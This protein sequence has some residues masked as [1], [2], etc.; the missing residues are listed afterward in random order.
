MNPARLASTFLLLVLSSIAA[1]AATITWKNPAGGLWNQST[2]WQPAQVPG[3]LDSVVIDLAGAFS[4][5]VNSAATVSNLSLGGPG[6]NPTLSLTAG[7][8]TVSQSGTIHDGAVL[9]FIGNGLA[10]NWTIEPGGRLDVSGPSQKNLFHSRILNQG[11]VRWLTGVVAYDFS[12]ATSVFT[13]AA[14]FEI[15]SSDSWTFGYGGPMPRFRNEGTVRKVASTGNSSFGNL[16]FENFGNLLVDQGNLTLN[17]VTGTLTGSANIASGSRLIFAQCSITN[18]APVNFS[19]PG[20]STFESGTLW[21]GGAVQ[22]AGLQL[23]GGNLQLLPT[24]QGGSIT[25]LVLQ[26]I[27]LNGTHQITGQLVL[28]NSPLAGSYII[29]AGGRLDFTGSSTKV[30]YE[31]QILNLGTI[32]WLEGIIAYDSTASGSVLTNRGLFEIQADS[33]FTFGYSGSQPRIQNEATIRKFNGTGTTTFN[34]LAFDNL[35]SIVVDKGRLNFQGV[36]G[37]LEGTGDVALGASLTFTQSSL[38]NTGPATFT[39]SGPAT[40]D[41]GTLSLGGGAPPAGLRLAGG[42]LKLLPSFQGGTIT[43]LTLQGTQLTGTNVVT[44]LLVISNAPLSGRYLIQPSGRVELVGNAQKLFYD[45]HILNLGTLR[46]AEGTVNYD[47]TA[48]GSTFTNLGLWELAPSGTWTYGYSGATPRIRNEGTIRKTSGAGTTSLNNLRFENAGQVRVDQGRVN[49]QSIEGVISGTFE[50]AQVA[51]FAFVSASLTNSTPVS[52]TGP[53]KSIFES[54]SLWLGGTV[55]PAGLQLIGG[56]LYLLPTF[57]GGVITNLTLEGIRLNGTN[58]IAGSL[59]VSNAPIVGRYLI[60]P[61]GRLDLVGN[62]SK[63]LYDTHVLNLGTLRWLA[64]PVSYDGTGANSTLTNLG[65]WEIH[66]DSSWSYPYS[67]ARPSIRNEGTLRKVNGPGQSTFNNLAFNNAGQIVIDQGRLNLQGIDGNLTGSANIAQGAILAFSNCDLTNS[68]PISIT[69]LGKAVF[70]SGSLWLGGAAQPQGLQLT[71]GTLRLLPTFQG[72]TISNLVLQGIT[73]VGTN[74]VQGVLSTT[75]SAVHGHLVIEPGGRYDISGSGLS[76]NE[77]WHVLNLGTVRWLSGTI[78]YGPPA[79]GSRFTN[80]NLVEIHSDSSWFYG[81]SGQVPT[82]RNE[83]TVRKLNGTGTTHFQ[84]LNFENPGIIEVANGIL[85]LPASYIHSTGILRPTGG[86]VGVQAGFDVIGGTVE[87]TGTILGARFLGGLLSPGGESTG[88]LRFPNGL[89]LAPAVTV[90]IHATGP[91]PATQHDRIRVTGPVDLGG[92]NLQ[93][94]TATGIGFGQSALFLENDGLDAITGTFAGRDEGS[95]FDVSTRLYRIRYKT[96]TG[97]DVS[98]IRDDGGIVLTPRPILT[99]GLYRV[100]GLGTNFVHY[101]IE[102]ST[103]LTDWIEL[104]TVPANGGGEFQFDD[105]DTA[106]FP[107]RLYRAIG[108]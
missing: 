50:T 15:H 68:A 51:T 57:Q 90:R 38:T 93:V 70:E 17:G 64:G 80:A 8:L 71:G 7:V 75:N 92:A 37:S 30:L 81:Y 106:Q 89:S 86:S 47:F 95:L 48:S 13:N 78:T 20:R 16:Q 23:V 18:S 62:G 79:L 31:S 9:E 65:V 107:H 99:N 21:L 25:N 46:W 41:S 44:G 61:T 55:Q 43:N 54:G 2:N 19:G 14:L 74:R 72:G 85:N 76:P 102:A 11:T 108:P 84:N 77:E 82:F 1:S 33:S 91:T 101:R 36:V 32:R 67:G 45:S 104:G 69:G 59:V 100:L 3:P 49:F 52:F 27:R 26:G 66:A 40:F 96:G 105:P 28:S 5:Q 24:F 6:S 87:G 97:N 53:G 42:S 34:N 103:N 98:L 60:L 73:L 94:P 63:Q 10:G 29:Q 58:Q 83:G 22:P 4:V 35:G 56:N 12:A 39:G 88:D